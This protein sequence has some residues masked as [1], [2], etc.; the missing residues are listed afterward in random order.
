MDHVDAVL[1]NG[2]IQAVAMA[3]IHCSDMGKA[4]WLRNPWRNSPLST[5]PARTST[6]ILF[7]NR[8]L[9]RLAAVED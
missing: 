5:R 7:V 1:V 2:T 8:N 6:L 9:F 4:F 3:W